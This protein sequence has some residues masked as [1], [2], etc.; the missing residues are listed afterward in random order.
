MIGALNLRTAKQAVVRQCPHRDCGDMV[1]ETTLSHVFWECKVAKRLWHVIGNVG[2]I[3]TCVDRTWTAHAIKF[4]TPSLHYPASNADATHAGGCNSTKLVQKVWRIMCYIGLHQLWLFR[5][6]AA[7]R[8]QHRDQQEAVPVILGK[9]MAAI[10]Q[11]LERLASPGWHPDQRDQQRRLRRFLQSLPL[12][13]LCHARRLTKRVCITTAE[14]E[15][16]LASQELA[17]YHS[18]SA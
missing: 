16:T 1:K 6:A 4:S 3:F 9:I 17:R 11:H 2:H 14:A 18:R 12:V 15:A 7:H 8:D 5:N 13:R 10:Y